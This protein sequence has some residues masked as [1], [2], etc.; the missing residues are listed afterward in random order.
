M[1]RFSLLRATLALPFL[2]TT[3]VL[4][5]R[6]SS[7][8]FADTL[9]QGEVPLIPREVLFGNPE[10]SGVSL[11]PDGKQI[12]FLAPHRGVLNLWAQELEAGSKPRLLT[13]STNRSTRAASWSVDGR[14]L[15]TSRDSYGDEN[16]VLIR[17]DPTTG[18]AIDLTPAKG[19]KA[20]IWGDDQDVPDELVIGLNDRDP[21]Y[22][23]L[24]V[25]N[26]E[27]GKWCLLYEANDGYL[28]SVDWID[29]D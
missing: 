17:I 4:P 25:I 20:A 16:T 21:R 3:I 6:L 2:L 29:G 15:I 11:S 19:V 8:A 7:P 13:N 24:W 27:T 22:H 10:V 5:I 23:D 1:R 9:S 26:L 28:V 14:Y 18:E 12:V